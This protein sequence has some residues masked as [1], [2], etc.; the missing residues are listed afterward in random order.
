MAHVLD[1]RRLEKLR[2]SWDSLGGL[3]TGEYILHLLRGRTVINEAAV[4]HHLHQGLVAVARKHGCVL[5]T[6]SRVASI[7]YSDTSKPVTVTT[8]L[9]HSY[10]F[11]LLL[12]SDGVNS[13]VRKTLSPTVTPKPPTNNSAYRAIVPYSR[14][15]ADP[16][17][18]SLIREGLSMDVW[19][20]ANKYIISY[21]ISAGKDFN[22]VLSHHT[23][24]PVHAVQDVNLQELKET[25][26]EFDER[27][28]RVL[29][30]IEHP[31]QRW[32]LL[33]TGPLKSWSS[34]CGRVVL[35]GDAAHS[36][37]NH[38]A[39]G[40]ATAMEDGAFLGVVIAAIIERKMNLKQGIALYEKE[41]MPKARKKQEVSFL[42]G[43]IW[44]LGGREAELRNQ[45]MEGELSGDGKILRRSP[46]LYGD[47][48]TV[49]SV[50]GY[51][52]EE[53]ARRALD[54]ELNGGTEV[55]GGLGVRMNTREEVMGWFLD[56]N[57]D[58][59]AKL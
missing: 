1:T 23:Q 24:Q 45:A 15:R 56:D 32:P 17:T 26:Q 9:G 12:G 20:S 39:Q 19:M 18:S 14:L 42:N 16:I 4:R 35:L 25:Y 43:A 30:M 54:T 51:D 36:M 34:E 57:E 46:N 7:S 55:M 44:H 40:A 22:M 52:A 50:Y 37:V 59:K 11:D 41:R 49:L 47:P 10:D 29:D 13:I 31:V 5:Y 28:R 2:R 3:F 8:H 53:H 58:L 6:N 48:T 33:V 38:M 21:P 27:I